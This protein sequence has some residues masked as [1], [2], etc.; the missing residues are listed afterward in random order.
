[1]HSRGN[2]SDF[3]DDESAHIERLRLNSNQRK[4][5]VDALHT[6]CNFIKLIMTTVSIS[7]V[8]QSE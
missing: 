1:M 7:I 8:R 4:Q 2:Y 5:P 3:S 6:A